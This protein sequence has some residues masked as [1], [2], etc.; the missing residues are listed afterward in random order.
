MA[1]NAGPVKKARVSKCGPKQHGAQS[2]VRVNPRITKCDLAKGV[3]MAAKAARQR[4]E[5]GIG[6]SCARTEA[7]LVK[8]EASITGFRGAEPSHNDRGHSTVRNSATRALPCIL[9]HPH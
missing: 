6:A 3:D 2:E 9:G 8:S 1:G 4:Y 5:E 7:A